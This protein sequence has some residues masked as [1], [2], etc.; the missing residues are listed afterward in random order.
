[1]VYLSKV[2]KWGK[3]ISPLSPYIYLKELVKSGNIG[4]IKKVKKQPI[5]NKQKVEE[6]LKQY[7]LYKVSLLIS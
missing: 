5:Q 7:H 3:I 4:I 1:M 6:T 2:K